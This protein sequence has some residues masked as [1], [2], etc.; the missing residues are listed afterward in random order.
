MFFLDSYC[1]D[2]YPIIRLI[3]IFINLIRFAVP[4][5]LILFVTID[6]VKAVIANNEDEMKK[7]QGIVVKRLIYAV[8]VFLVVSLVMLVM[9]I[10]ADVGASDLS[11]EDF[12]VRSWKSCWGCNSKSECKAID[13][14]SNSVPSQER[15]DK[16]DKKYVYSNTKLP[17]HDC[18][19]GADDPDNY[20]KDPDTGNLYRFRCVKK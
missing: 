20:F 1:T 19:G 16:N 5:A 15:V 6:F 3:K 9:D 14:K 17:D 12:D 18:Q 2:L 4:I 13:N 10:V 11:G 7:A 8:A